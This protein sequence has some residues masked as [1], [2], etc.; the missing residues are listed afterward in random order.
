MGNRSGR[1]QSGHQAT[2]QATSNEGSPGDSPG[3]GAV[4]I[5]EVAAAVQ[6]VS[7]TESLPDGVLCHILAKLPF[8]ERAAVACTCRGLQHLVTSTDA[9][10]TSFHLSNSYFVDV[11]LICLAR[12]AQ[13]RLLK[14][15]VI[16][17]EYIT[18][19]AMV[20]AARKNRGLVRYGTW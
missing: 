8:R 6:L 9:L 2:G 17:C 13:G 18:P 16:D 15:T 10:W 12:Q 14:L 1:Q 7:L 20:E 5:A 4:E 3:P 11:A 19:A